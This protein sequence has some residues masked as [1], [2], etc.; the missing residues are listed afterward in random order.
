[1]TICERLFIELDNRNL[2]AYGLCQTLG[3]NT[4]TT[5]NWKQRGT[6]PP[7]KYIVPICEYL[8]C[9]LE[10]FLTGQDSTQETKKAPSPGLSKRGQELIGYFEQLGEYEQGVVLGEARGLLL[11]TS[12][13]GKK[14]TG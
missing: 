13:A 5:S 11:A 14:A 6:D 12:S 2:T 1:M 4:T 7:A 9:S 10:Y 3:I 8:G